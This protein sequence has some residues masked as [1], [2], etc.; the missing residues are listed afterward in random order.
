[1]KHITEKIEQ[2]DT[3]IIHGHIRPDG[4]CIGSHY[5]LL[6]LIKANYPN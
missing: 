3:I 1:M 5:G 4:D 2:F 6:N